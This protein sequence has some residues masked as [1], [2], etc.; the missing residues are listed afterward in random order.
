MAHKLKILSLNVRGL[1]NTNKRRAIFSN[2]KNQ[3]A[4]IFIACEQA[5]L[6]GRAKRSARKHASEQ[7][8]R[9]GPVRVPLVRV[10]FTISPKWRAC[11]QA[12]IFNL[13]ETFSKPEDEKIWTAEWGGKLF[14]SHGTE[15]L[16]G[17]TMLINPASKFQVSHYRNSSPR[18]VL[19]HLTPSRAYNHLCD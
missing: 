6:F 18:E 5:L 13:Q 15:H 14:F 11:S 10:L 8:S 1:R 2:L 16:K 9:E 17:V 19:N 7:R 12:T 4:T 3:K